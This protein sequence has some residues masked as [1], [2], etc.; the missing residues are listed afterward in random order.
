MIVSP[1]REDDKETR[2]VIRDILTIALRTYKRT[3]N[4]ELVPHIESINNYYDFIVD[5]VDNYDYT[6]DDKKRVKFDRLLYANKSK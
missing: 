1:T 2:D 6:E 4:E 5:K 3:Q